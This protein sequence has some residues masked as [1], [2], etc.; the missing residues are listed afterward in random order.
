[1]SYLGLHCLPRSHL[2]DAGDKKVMSFLF[3]Y[4]IFDEGDTH[5]CKYLFY[6]VVP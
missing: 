2:L 6:L 5:S 4:T 3:I 1:M